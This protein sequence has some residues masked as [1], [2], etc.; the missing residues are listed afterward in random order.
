MIRIIIKTIRLLL[1]FISG[2]LAAIFL[3]FGILT[4]CSDISIGERAFASHDLMKYKP[5]LDESGKLGF[6]DLIGLNPDV[7][8]WITIYGT[9]IDYPVLQGHSDMEYINKDVFGNYAIPGSIFLSVINKK[10]FS[11][12]YQL[13]YGHNMENG[14]MFGDI[15]KFKDK[16]FFYSVKN[17]EDGVLITK[18]KVY[19]INILAILKTDAFDPMIYKANKSSDDMKETLEYLHEK[20][21]YSKDTGDAFHIIAL[22]TCDGGASYG[23]LILICKVVDRIL[24]LYE[25][26]SEVPKEKIKTFGHPEIYGQFALLNLWILILSLYMTYP[27]HLIGRTGFRNHI[28]GNIACL[29]ACVVSLAVFI[30]TEDII[31]PLTVIDQWTPL[32]IGIAYIIWVIRYQGNP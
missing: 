25:S 19:D 15:D 8:A 5:Q 32:M 2:F 17:R 7:V 3:F 1:H 12:P 13:I 31:R 29:F 27:L 6:E 22:S 16:K 18:E 24:P 4:L 11:E 28:C 30:I 14:S 10:D 26:E 21:I 23:R 20:A 9:N